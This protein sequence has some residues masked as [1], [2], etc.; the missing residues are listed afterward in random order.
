MCGG[1]ISAR[2]F[3]TLDDLPSASPCW[4]C[5]F[6]AEAKGNILLLENVMDLV[7]IFDIFVNFRTAFQDD[8]TSEL[9]TDDYDVAI[10][11]HA[12]AHV[13]RGGER[14]GTARGAAPPCGCF[15]LRPLP[16]ACCLVPWKHPRTPDR[17]SGK[18]ER[19]MSK[20]CCPLAFPI[21]SLIL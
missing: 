7:F 11:R 16:R 9:I 1:G 15:C 4:T 13:K 20:E 21:S 3:L 8:V 5:A 18:D 17:Q 6:S 12:P 14:A 19:S 2:A 10:V